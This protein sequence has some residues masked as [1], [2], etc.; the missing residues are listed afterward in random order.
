MLNAIAQNAQKLVE[1]AQQE[2]AKLNQQ[3][4]GIIDRLTSIAQKVMDTTKQI[5]EAVIN[6]IKSMFGLGKRSL[7]L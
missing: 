5:N 7:T 3:H 1:E 4:L 2:I 6:K